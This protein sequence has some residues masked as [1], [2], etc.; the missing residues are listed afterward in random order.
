M[1]SITTL[2]QQNAQ[3][4]SL[5]VYIITLCVPTHFNPSGTIRE[6]YYSLMM[7]RFGLKHVG[8]ISVKLT[9]YVRQHIMRYVG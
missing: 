8:I 2:V 1:L 7:I 5:D 6:K 4:S 9:L 3:C